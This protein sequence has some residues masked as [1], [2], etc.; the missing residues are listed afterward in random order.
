MTSCENV[1]RATD[2]LP[3]LSTIFSVF[4]GNATSIDRGQT[5]AASA[6]GTALTTDLIT[7]TSNPT[8]P[9]TTI[10]AAAAPWYTGTSQTW[11]P[12]ATHF[13]EVGMLGQ[14]LFDPPQIQASIGDVVLFRFHGQN[15]SVTESTLESPCETLQNGFDSGFPRVIKDQIVNGSVSFEVDVETPR[16]FYCRQEKPKSHCLRGMVF[17]L[18][19]RD[20]MNDFLDNARSTASKAA[21][22]DA[23]PDSHSPATFTTW[24]TST[25]INTAATLSTTTLEL[26][27]NET[28]SLVNEPTEE[29]VKRSSTSESVAILNATSGAGAVAL[30]TVDVASALG[31]TLALAICV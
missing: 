29:S 3:V 30:M 17:A 9:P 13:V 12:Q 1:P 14:L 6:L 16:W 21:V 18:N 23:L 2:V 20:K 24:T 19:P 26:V 5:T 31:L 27:G 28:A 7:G 4:A 8:A 10:E 25:T 15:H 11:P 22:T